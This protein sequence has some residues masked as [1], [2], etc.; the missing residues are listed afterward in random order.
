M[1]YGPGISATFL[2]YF[3]STAIVFA[4]ITAQSL[5]TGISGFPQQVGLVGGLVG[6]LIGVY[7][8]RTVTLSVSKQAGGKSEFSKG[9]KKKSGKAIAK[10]LPKLIES[11]GY[12]LVVEPEDEDEDEGDAEAKEQA[13]A[14]E[15][16]EVDDQTVEFDVYQ[17]RGF[18]KFFS[19]K[20]FVY[21]ENGETIVS[22]RATH[23]RALKR[24]L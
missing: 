8:N 1:Q 3:T 10:T 23:I 24:L 13:E 20:I 21:Q 14:K 7:F 15:K 5:G 9:N 22:S 11:M 19:G 18:S 12:E 2:Y 6:G 16:T 4:F 17:R